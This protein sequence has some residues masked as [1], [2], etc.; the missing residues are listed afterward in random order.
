MDKEVQATLIAAIVEQLKTLRRDEARGA[1]RD[2][3]LVAR[4]NR[5]LD[6]LLGAPV[7]WQ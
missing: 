3:E 4:L 2:A 7:D 5:A 6:W 1:P